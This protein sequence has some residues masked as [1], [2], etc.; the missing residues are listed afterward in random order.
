[1]AALLVALI[2]MRGVESSTDMY[3]VV[4]LMDRIARWILLPSLGLTLVSGLLAMAAVPAYHGAGWV[5]AKLATGVLTFEGSL[6]A[7]QGP[8]QSLAEEA[9]M[10]ATASAAYV[11][12]PDQMDALHGSLVTLMAVAVV[13]IA[14]GI[15]RPRKRVR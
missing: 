15:W 11:I 13:N 1:M 8:V 12:P 10:S 9:A 6:M 5:W 14:L 7:I 4:S 2:Q 3:L